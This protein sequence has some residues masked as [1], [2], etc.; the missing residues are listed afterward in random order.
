M[1]SLAR[2][3]ASRA[4]A[5]GATYRKA[6][7]YVP[8]VTVG[9]RDLGAVDWTALDYPALCRIR[10]IMATRYEPTT[11]NRTLSA[12][13]S[14]ARQL[15]RDHVITR[16]RCA[17]LLEVEGLPAEWK[18]LRTGRALSSDEQGKLLAAA[19]LETK[20][21]LLYQAIVAL[22]LA[23]GLRR[24]E[25]AA[26]MSTGLADLNQRTGALLVRHGKGRKRREVF[27]SGRGLGVL[28]AFTASG[29]ARA[30]SPDAVGRAL[31]RLG[32]HADIEH[33]TPHDCRRTVA[34]TLIDKKVDLPTVAAILGHASVRQTAEYD[35]RGEDR[36][37]DAALDPWARP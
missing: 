4:P 10:E 31:A 5:T 14:F 28:R 22:A 1:V 26:V 34:S 15:A 33:F 8:L 23:G 2:F 32:R 20:E 12:A 21:P 25:I 36:L 18:P 27:I 37:R 6:L 3:L 24:A 9:R 7:E 13:R 19:A 35:R 29:G 30:L 11:V 16:E 17:E